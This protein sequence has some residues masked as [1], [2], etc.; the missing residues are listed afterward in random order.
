MLREIDDEIQPYHQR[1]IFS[2]HP[3]LSFL[4]VNDDRP[5]ASY[6]FWPEG[7]A[8]RLRLLK[9]RLPGLRAITEADRPP[10]GASLRQVM[11]AAGLLWTARR[12]AGKA[13]TRLPIDPEWDSQGRR[14]E[15]VR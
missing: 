10:T 9:D 11:D 7:P 15:L 4:L 5:T 6:P 8:E 12:I 13:I 2:A 14:I 3:E 1:R